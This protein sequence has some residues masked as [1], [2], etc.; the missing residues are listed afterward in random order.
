MKRTQPFEVVVIAQDRATS[1]HFDMPEAAIHT[2]AVD[3]VLGRPWPRSRK[4]DRSRGK[5]FSN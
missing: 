3:Y 1:A 5:A 4:T 2:G